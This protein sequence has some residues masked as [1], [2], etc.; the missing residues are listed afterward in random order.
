VANQ[1]KYVIIGGGLAGASAVEGIRAHDASGTIALIGKEDRLPY[2]RPPL[3]KGLWLGKTTLAELPLHDEGFYKSHG[4]H[5]FLNTEI[6]EIDRRKNQV[7]DR[8]GARYYYEKLLLASGG[9]PRTLS[10]GQGAVQYYRTVDDYL[11]LK[12]AAEHFDTFLLL[13]GGF[14]AAELASALTAQGR[15]VTVVFPDQFL[16]QKILPGALAAFVTDYYRDKGVDVV[17]SDVA[18]DAERTGGQ[19]HM[20]TKSGRRVAVDHAV[21]AIGLNL[22][23][24]MAKRAG[25]KIENGVEVNTFLQTSDPSIYAAGDIAHYPA[26]FLDKSVRFEHWNNAQALGRRSGENMAG[27]GKP[28]EY[29]PYF[30]SDLFDLGFEAVGDLDARFQTIED[31]R[32]EFREGV[33]YY[34]DGEKVKGILL[35]NVWEKVDDARSLI[36]QGKKYR[37]PGDLKNKL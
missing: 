12:E 26:K 9:T 33:V 21:A 31:W 23:T 24:E 29:L 15:K 13:G 3:S 6:V 27:A 30:W 25:L 34:L 7:S 10:F 18:V 1:F 11:V 2:D 19:V 22:H 28:F 4:V 20:R 36:E 16:L 14:I 8:N 35:W 37:R 17:S 32:K 5:L